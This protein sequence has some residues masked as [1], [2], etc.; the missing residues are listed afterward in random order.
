MRECV[1]VAFDDCIVLRHTLSRRVDVEAQ[2]VNPICSSLAF[3]RSGKIK[4]PTRK[5]IYAPA[6]ECMIEMEIVAQLGLK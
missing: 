5:C 4:P 3:H 1:R 2:Q 6:G